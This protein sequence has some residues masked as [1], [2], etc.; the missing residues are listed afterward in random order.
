MH[1]DWLASIALYIPLKHI[2]DLEM[3][4]KYSY[5][6]YGKEARRK[7]AEKAAKEK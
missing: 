6:W 4:K 2:E 7:A 5:K 1:L 3:S